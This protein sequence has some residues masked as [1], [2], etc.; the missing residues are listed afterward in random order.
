MAAANPKWAKQE[1]A[2]RNEED[3][4]E[5]GRIFF[6]NLAY[7]VCEA[8]L[9]AVFE[10]FGPVAECNLPIDVVTRAI[11]GFG[12]VTFVMPEHAVRAFSELDGTIFHGRLLHLI[13]GKSRDDEALDAEADG[14]SFKQRKQLQQKKEAGS[15]HNWNTLFM[16]A[17][18]VANVLASTYATS[19]EHVLDA[20]TGGSGAAVRL[21][22]GETEIIIEMKAFLERND[23]VLDAFEPS[24]Q[25]KRSGTVIVAKNLTAGTT[26]RELQPLFGKFGL[27][28]RLVLP[29]SGV[30][31]L[32]EFLE[33]TE[34]RAAF[35]KLAYSKFKTLPLYLEWAPEGT[36]RTAA[37]KALEQL[38]DNPFEK[39]AAEVEQTAK[40]NAFSDS[41]RAEHAE[42]EREQAEKNAAAAAADAEIA[43]DT[44]AEADTTLFLRNLNFATREP[45]IR[46]HFAALGKIHSVQVAL[47]KD[48]DNPQR[49]ISLGY[50]FIQFKRK[51][52]A[53]RALQELQFT[54]IE[55]NKVELKRSDRT[56][57]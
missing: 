41:R 10:P 22:L 30:T 5:S 44:P 33:P 52:T 20:A 16:G 32:V 2:L 8:D 36:F 19:K 56:L 35:R 50:G 42:K 47:K 28:G 14:L 7:T 11:K 37:T 4:S 34:A 3:I 57:Q 48:P 40:I 53:E 17:D 24:T 39:S 27:L 43:D 45:A 54:Q 26:A 13:P 15:A 55:G 9:R 38:P 51:E 49:P 25:M 46:Q 23:V 21:A 6:R 29:P 12:T 31:A 1:D 18:Q